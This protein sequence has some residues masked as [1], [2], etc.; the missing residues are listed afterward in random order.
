MTRN[1]RAFLRGA[2]IAGLSACGVLA[3]QSG[4]LWLVALSSLGIN[5]L[6]ASNVRAVSQTEGRW[7]FA[8]GAACGSVLTVWLLRTP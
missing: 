5:L 7:W 4:N 3:I 2:P 1:L 6:W 8:L